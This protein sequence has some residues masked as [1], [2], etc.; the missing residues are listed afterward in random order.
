MTSEER[1]IKLTKLYAI[2]EFQELILQD[3]I[4]QDILRLVLE[5]NVDSEVIRDELKARSILHKYF[6]DIIEQ[7]EIA[8]TENK[9]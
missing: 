9:D 5:D 6:Y 7:A 1:A 8:K 3:F 2:K 4:D